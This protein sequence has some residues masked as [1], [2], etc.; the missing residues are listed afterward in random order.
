[1]PIHSRCRLRDLCTLCLCG[2]T[3]V[4]REELAV[5]RPHRQLVVNA[6]PSWPS[7]I[8]APGGSIL[9]GVTSTSDCKDFFSSAPVL[10]RQ[11]K[12]AIRQYVNDCTWLPSR[13]VAVTAG[14][15][16]LPGWVCQSLPLASNHNGSVGHAS[17][18]APVTSLSSPR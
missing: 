16:Q 5:L 10:P 15:M 18:D 7:Q 14:C 6:K 9:F 12:A 17:Q 3:E 4:C 2:E 11:P 8:H 13:T 1:M